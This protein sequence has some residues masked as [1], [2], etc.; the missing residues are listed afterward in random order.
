MSTEPRLVVE[1]ITNDLAGEPDPPVV[2]ARLVLVFCVIVK[3][4]RLGLMLP[5][6][7]LAVMEAAS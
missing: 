3:P 4:L 5:R 1:V 7:V 6:F 2:A